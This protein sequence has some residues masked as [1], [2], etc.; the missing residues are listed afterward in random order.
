MSDRDENKT[1]DDALA[2]LTDQILAGKVPPTNGDPGLD[3]LA[4]TVR[5]LNA[6]FG[7]RALDDGAVTRVHKRLMARWTALRPGRVTRQGQGGFVNWLQAN[8]RRLSL[9]VPLAVVLLLLVLTPWLLTANPIIPGTAG[10][11]SSTTVVLI[12]LGILLVVAIVFGLKNRR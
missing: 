8:R 7:P 4:H 10:T 11:A 12:G 9:V 5:R 6:A 2:D 3:E 1:L